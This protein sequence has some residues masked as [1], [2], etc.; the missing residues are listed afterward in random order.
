MGTGCPSDAAA[1]DS[2]VVV[3]VTDAA[4]TR[5]VAKPLNNVGRN[6]MFRMPRSDPLSFALLSSKDLIHFVDSSH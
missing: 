5:P 4:A 3:K 1:K 2:A 6:R